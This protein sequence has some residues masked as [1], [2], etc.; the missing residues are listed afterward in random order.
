VIPKRTCAQAIAD[1]L[2]ER[3]LAGEIRAVQEHADRAEGRPRQSIEI[4]NAALRDA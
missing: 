2:A 1:G 3:A 4:E